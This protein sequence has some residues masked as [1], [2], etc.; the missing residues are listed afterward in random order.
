MLI[1]RW[2]SRAQPLLSQN[3]RSVH[4]SSTAAS[5][6][7]CRRSSPWKSCRSEFSRR[8][9]AASNY[10]LFSTSTPTRSSSVS[11]FYIPSFNLFGKGSLNEAANQIKMSGYKKIL[12]VTDPGIIKIGLCDKVKGLL[13]ERGST[14][15]I[16]NGVQPNPTV[17]NVK[18]GLK[19]IKEFGCD[20]IVSIGGG[21][22]HDCAKGIA[23]LATNGGKIADYEGVDKSLK[24]QLPL[25]SIN[26]TAGTASE[27]T[28]FA[29]ITEETRHI[30]MSIIDKH[31]MPCLSVNDPETMYGLPPS[32]TAATGMDALTHAVEAYVST[33]ANPIT[34]ACALK[35][36]ELVGQYLNRAV[37]NG[38]DEEA[39]EKMAYAQFL[40]GM[41]FNNASLG[42]VHAMAHQLGGFY[43]I[44]HGIC[45]AILLPHVQLFNSKDAGAAARLGDVAAQ[46][47]CEEHTAQAAI[48]K[49]QKLNEQVGVNPYL[50][51]LGVFEKDFDNLSQNAMKDACGAT[52]PIQPTLDE[53]KS[54][55]AAAY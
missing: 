24:P 41:A 1:N 34:D 47:G 31:T 4:F 25:V 21:S 8:F 44:P 50:K 15:Y 7:C 40:G 22:A 5:S 3:V 53:V 27:M 43:N 45:N 16:Y 32:L 42:Y 35:C 10:N 29:I 48:E 33:A 39:R 20:S 12:I 28:R 26:T 19:L 36:M 17:T 18:D 9:F 11:A 37:K 30:K 54:I 46:L 23:L 55:F 2:I 49:I 52:N 13:E 51:D 6:V 14:V 38:K